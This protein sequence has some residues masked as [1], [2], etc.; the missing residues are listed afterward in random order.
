MCHEL[1]LGRSRQPVHSERETVDIT[2]MSTVSRSQTVTVTIRAKPPQAGR[3]TL[4]G[5]GYR[6]MVVLNEGRLPDINSR[7][8]YA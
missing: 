8:T 1:A 2:V 6:F 3:H 7:S 4:K 5:A